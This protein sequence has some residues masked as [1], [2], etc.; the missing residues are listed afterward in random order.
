M[1]P[2]PHCAGVPAGS[3]LRIDT[4]DFAIHCIYIQLYSQVD[5]DTLTTSSWHICNRCRLK[6]K[7]EDG[8]QALILAR[9]VCLCVC[10]YVCV[11]VCVCLC[12][13]VCVC[14]CV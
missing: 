5:T 6:M 13:C 4:L 10:V 8:V 7:D 12:V 11:F 9:Y 3:T 2:V 1:D 14:V